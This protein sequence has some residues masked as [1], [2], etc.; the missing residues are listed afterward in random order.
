[1]PLAPWHRVGPVHANDDFER[2][3]RA[4]STGRNGV[5][6]ADDSLPPNGQTLLRAFESLISVLNERK[7]HYAIIGGLAMIQ[8]S[9]V[10]TT[11]DIDALLTLPQIAM[12]GF[13]ESLGARGFEVW[14]RRAITF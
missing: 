10:R 13:F 12:P 2:K 9:R 14:V 4:N 8:H 5:P 6:N 11:D 3:S 7:V 1:M